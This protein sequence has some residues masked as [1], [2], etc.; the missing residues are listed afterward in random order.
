MPPQEKDYLYNIFLKTTNIEVQKENINISKAA[1]MQTVEALSIYSNKGEGDCFF[2]SIADAINDYNSTNNYKIVNG[3]YGNTQIFT[4]LYLRGIVLEHIINSPVK[5]TYI[6]NSLANTDEMNRIFKEQLQQIQQ[7][8][9][10]PIDQYLNIANDIYKSSDNFLVKN[11][12]EIPIMEEDYFKPF[13]PISIENER[14]LSQYINS[15]DYWANSLAVDAISNKLKLK[16]IPIEKTN[17]LLSIWD[18]NASSINTKWNHYMFLYH[19]KHNF[20]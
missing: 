20:L 14:E 9:D 5:E 15:P 12:H 16:I 11:V 17:G 6:Q 7:D 2:I 19:K 8:E 3:I 18:I 13:K 10:I 4:P 1:Y